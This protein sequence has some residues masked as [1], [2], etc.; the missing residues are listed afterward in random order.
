[1]A[2]KQI[3]VDGLHK[4]IDLEKAIL[5]KIDHPFIVKLHYSFQTK[6]KI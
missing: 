6:D 1:M 5:L 3:D 2:K 4:N